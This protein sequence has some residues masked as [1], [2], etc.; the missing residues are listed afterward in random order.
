MFADF[1]NDA[2]VSENS[3]IEIDNRE[4]RGVAAGDVNGDGHLDLVVSSW[5]N[6]QMQLYLGHGDLTFE[7]GTQFGR[8]AAK[9]AQQG[10][11]L[12][13]YDSDG[14]I[15]LVLTGHEPMKD[16]MAPSPCTGTM[17]PGA[18][19]TRPSNRGFVLSTKA[20]TAG[21]SVIWT[22]TPTSMP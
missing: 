10:I 11:M 15:D 5:E 3:G 22:G 7:R 19:S 16:A 17:A 2:D 1:D 4:P 12:V 20:S 13:D 21:L 14:D 9:L 18:L 8:R 6:I